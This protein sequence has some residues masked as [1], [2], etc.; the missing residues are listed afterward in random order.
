MKKT[1]KIKRRVIHFVLFS[2]AS[3]LF[4]ACSN[5]DLDLK[6]QDN[7]K[8]IEKAIEIVN[9]TN[10]LKSSGIQFDNEERETVL[11][12]RDEAVFMET[13]VLL[14]GMSREERENWNKQ[15]G[16]FKSLDQMYNL[17]MQ[18][19]DKL[20]FTEEEYKQFKEKYSS[21]LYFPEYK[22]DFGAY[23][24][25]ESL[26]YAYI[27]DK[28]GRY[29]IGDK[30][31][32]LNKINTYEQLQKSGQAMYSL[33]EIESNKT[34]KATAGYNNI[35]R[36]DVKSKFAGQAAS[37][38]FRGGSKNGKKL[39]FKVGR[40]IKPFTS[41]NPTGGNPILH[42][43][44]TSLDVEITFRKKGFLG[45]WYNYSSD[46]DTEITCLDKTERFHKSGV[47]S[48]DWT[49]QYLLP[50]LKRDNLKR[51]THYAELPFNIKTDYR[52][53]GDLLWSGTIEPVIVTH[54]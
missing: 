44:N 34:L 45:K 53:I 49:S 19:A 43:V 31:V 21:F 24:P 20:D 29:I 23:V 4:N 10:T 1:R 28:R 2:C 32:E 5:D 11:K 22:D 48:H 52:G 9:I 33:E 27:T 17:A 47:S 14:E 50:V 7:T 51:E 38:W 40:R 54:P 36:V 15:F 18:E 25:F 39:Q 13:L 3:V 26:S 46:T 42:G 30:V 6:T 12:F 16:D 41:P 35:K 37:D 8:E